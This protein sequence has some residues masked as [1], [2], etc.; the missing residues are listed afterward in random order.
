MRRLAV[1]IVMVAALPVAQAGAADRVV[2]TV[3]RATPVD[4]YAGHALWSTWD[5]SAYRLTESTGG[6]IQTLPVAPSAVPFDADAGSDAHGAPVAVYSRCRR[7]PLSPWALDGR[8]GCDLYEYRFA[9][10]RE[11][12]ITRAN[13]KADEYY[14][15]VWHGRLAFT[16]TYRNGDRRL[17]W[18][19]LGHA[20]ASHRLRGGPTEEEAVPVDLDFRSGTVAFMWRFEFGGELRIAKTNGT[21]RRLVRI[22]GSGAAANQIDGQG[23]SITGGSVYWMLS[24]TGDD[25]VW[26]RVRRVRVAPR[27][28]QQATTRIDAATSG[29]AHDRSASWYVRDAGAGRF[30][31]HRAAGLRY[32]HADPI[33]LE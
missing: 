22:P 3:A 26:S 33:V 21:G 17:Y 18:R 13:S 27:R 11:I 5:G 30:E 14:P 25:P 32:E 16:R 2:A 29:F 24:V 15:A 10:G 20:G 23:P 19:T 4:V 8:R 12:R 9:T 31:I 28:Q 7:A 1:V 6:H